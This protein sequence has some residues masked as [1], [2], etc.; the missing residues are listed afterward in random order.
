MP[1]SDKGND[2]D[3]HE[4]NLQLDND[5]VLD[6]TGSSSGFDLSIVGD[7]NNGIG[8]DFNGPTPDQEKPVED[9]PFVDEIE[10][11][12]LHPVK[13]AINGIKGKKKRKT[14]NDILGFSKVN[15]RYKKGGGSKKKCVVLR[16]AVAAEALSASISS[17]G[18][19]NRN[20]I[21]LNKA[22]T[23][24]ELNK[25]VGIGYEGDEEEVISKIAEKIAEENDN[26][27]Y[28]F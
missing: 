13:A 21:I 1:D 15:S 17:D 23:I 27:S 9:G 19:A 10:D 11:T 7:T 4:R 14:I 6:S 18:I 26:A 3:S 12:Q 20:R 25:L 2:L 24:W 28:Q 16:S 8:E 22:Q 5:I